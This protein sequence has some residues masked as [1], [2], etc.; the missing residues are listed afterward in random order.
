M[1]VSA[2]WD[3]DEQTIVRYDF[4]GHWTWEEFYPV[5][6]Q[7]IAM[8]RGVPHRV[9]VILNMLKSQNIPISILT[10]ARSIAR[11]QPGNLGISVI[12]TTNAAILSLYRAGIKIDSGIAHYFAATTTLDDAYRII[13]EAREKLT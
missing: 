7:A 10:H 11:K 5:Y 9:D 3:N 8:E 1:S 6:E 13:N 2:W 4:E 12:V